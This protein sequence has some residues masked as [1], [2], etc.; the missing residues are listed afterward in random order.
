ML[1]N[2]LTLFLNVENSY[3]HFTKFN[4]M[5]ERHYNVTKQQRHIMF[6]NVLL[7]L[8]FKEY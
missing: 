7:N 6:Q 5:F 3:L 1:K 8:L 2:H 4:R